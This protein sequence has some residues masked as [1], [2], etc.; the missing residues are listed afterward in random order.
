MVLPFQYSVLN[1]DAKKNLSTNRAINDDIPLAGIQNSGFIGS[2]TIESNNV[3]NDLNGPANHHRPTFC[4]ET[5][6]QRHV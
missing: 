1:G 5:I 4:L 2:S 3:A 6:P